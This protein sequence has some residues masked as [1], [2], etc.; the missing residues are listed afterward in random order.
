LIHGLGWKAL[1]EGV[2]DPRDGLA[3]WTAGFDGVTGRAV[4]VAAG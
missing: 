3:L 1:A 2:D 4:E